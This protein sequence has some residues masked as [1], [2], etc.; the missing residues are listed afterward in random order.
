[1]QGVEEEADY[2]SRQGPDAVVSGHAP[3]LPAR[4]RTLVQL[5]IDYHFG[6]RSIDSYQVLS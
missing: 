6:P 5:N 1:M 2:Q 3:P 4:L